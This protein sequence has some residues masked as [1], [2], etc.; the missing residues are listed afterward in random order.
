MQFNFSEVL[1][2]IS[3]ENISYKIQWNTISLFWI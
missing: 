2:N 1:L 3:K